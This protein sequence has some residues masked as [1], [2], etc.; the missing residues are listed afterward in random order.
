MEALSQFGALGQIV[1][2]G[3]SS[4]GAVALVLYLHRRLA[5]GTVRRL[6][7]QLSAMRSDLTKL[8]LI[9]EK[10]ISPAMESMSKS[11]EALRRDI[12]RGGGP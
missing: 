9:N 4:A 2:G 6:L 3:G 1:L 10:V 11:I 7:E 5:N 12:A 8:V